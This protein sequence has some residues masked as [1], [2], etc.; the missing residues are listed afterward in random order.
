MCKSIELHRMKYKWHKAVGKQKVSPCAATSYNLIILTLHK[1][2]DNFSG[3]TS[4]KKVSFCIVYR[5]I[6]IFR[7]EK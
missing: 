1:Y 3:H 2:T 6:S 7:C 4:L 5:I